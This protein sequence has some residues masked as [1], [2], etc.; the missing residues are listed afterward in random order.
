MTRRRSSTR[1]ERGGVMA[2]VA[3]FFGFAVILG[4]ASL[5]IDTGKLMWERREL[6]NGA[7]AAALSLA[8]NCA[9]GVGCMENNAGVQE[10]A[11]G[12]AKDGLHTIERECRS[13]AVVGALPECTVPG[14]M[15]DLEQCPPLPPDYASAAG[16]KYVEVRTESL[17]TAGGFVTNLLARA[18]GG[19]DRSTLIACARAAWG[20]A[21][22]ASTLPLTIAT[23]EYQEAFALGSGVE[24][25]IPLKYAKDANACDPHTAPSGGDFSGGFGFLTHSG[26]V[27]K[28]D[29]KS[30]VDASTGIG[31]ANE[32]MP[33]IKVGEVIYIPVFDCISASKTFCVTGKP[34]GTQTNYHIDGYA[35]FKVTAFDVASVKIG[36]PGTAAKKECKDE[37]KDNKCIFGIFLD[38]YVDGTGVIDPGGGTDYGA[39]TVQ[40]MG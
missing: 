36:T 34:S 23:C 28:V 1:D 7:D 22:S 6:Q 10:L 20:P 30:W 4:A 31:K 26:C 40:P 5:A 11:D 18:A 29:S 14:D 9:K 35:A 8:Q 39:V 21:K 16:L 25:A 24:T 32:C 15:S 33:T 27:V 38:D 17:S 13:Q 37:S 19:D 12:N 2:L 3:L